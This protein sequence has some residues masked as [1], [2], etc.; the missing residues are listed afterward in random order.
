MFAALN[1]LEIF[2]LGLPQSQ[3]K[4]KCYARVHIFWIRCRTVWSMKMMGTEDPWFVELPT[5]YS[6]LLVQFQQN[7]LLLLHIWNDK[8]TNISTI[9]L[10]VRTGAPEVGVRGGWRP[11]PEFALAYGRGPFLGPFS[12][13]LVEFR[14]LLALRLPSKT[15]FR[16]PCYNRI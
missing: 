13:F 12:A 1:V 16:R 14:A 11:P 6:R 7:H 3:I 15:Y 4:L 8:K 9:N 10:T 2:W 5:Y